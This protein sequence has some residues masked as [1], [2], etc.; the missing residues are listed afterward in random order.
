[1][2]RGFLAAC[3]G[4]IGIVL[5]S[6]PVMS[7]PSGIQT[8]FK[9]TRQEVESLKRESLEREVFTISYEEW[10]AGI[11][12]PDS[13]EAERLKLKARFIIDSPQKVK[14]YFTKTD[15]ESYESFWKNCHLDVSRL[16]FEKNNKESQSQQ[17]VGDSLSLQ[18]GRTSENNLSRLR[19]IGPNWSNKEHNDF[20]MN[21]VLPII[22]EMQVDIDRTYGFGPRMI[23][24]ETGERIAMPDRFLDYRNL[25]EGEKLLI[26]MHFKH[27]ARYYSE[28]NKRKPILK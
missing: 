2:G 15:L 21:V 28:G 12:K 22:V 5:S 24:S 27:E 20:L 9:V 13:K 19:S 14:S 4:L 26:Y 6:T 7:T 23:K 18:L 16:P 10:K 11:E 25:R 8:N 3:A 17:T 1:M